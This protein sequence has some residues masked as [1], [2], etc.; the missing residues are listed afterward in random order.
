MLD[1]LRKHGL[2]T[3]LKRCQFH[4][5]EIC[6]LGYIILAQEVKIENK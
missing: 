2:F 4:I 5:N 1:V 3:N 6:F